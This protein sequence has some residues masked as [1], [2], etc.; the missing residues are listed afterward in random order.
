MKEILI[1]QAAKK[2]YQELITIWESSVRATHHFL[3]ESDIVTY[4]ELILDQ[5]FDQVQLYSAKEDGKISG[6]IGISGEAIQMLFIHADARGKGLGKKLIDFVKKEH[7]IN[8]VDVNEQNDQAVG[9][10]EKLGFVT[11]SRSEL[12]D[13]GKPYP[14]LSME[15]KTTL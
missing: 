9:F 3:S 6:F 15:L 14:I 12:D 5:Y 10:Y 2:D 7:G 4:R 11:V 8:T 1:E 13:A